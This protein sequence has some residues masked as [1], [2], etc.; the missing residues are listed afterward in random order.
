MLEDLLIEGDGLWR[1][2]GQLHERE[3]IG[4]AL[5]ANADGTVPHVRA[6]CLRRWIVVDVD[7]AIQI[8]HDDARDAAELDPVHHTV[9]EK[10]GQRDRGQV[11]HGRLLGARVLHDLRTVAGQNAIEDAG[12]VDGLRKA[13]GVGDGAREDI[14]DPLTDDSSLVCDQ[15]TERHTRLQVSRVNPL[16]HLEGQIAVGQNELVIWRTVEVGHGSHT[17][18]S[19][20]HAHAHQ[21]LLLAGLLDRDE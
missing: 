20:L 7:D 4:E 3:H 14:D 9:A 8:A 11:T 16:C 17:V 1:L 10:V 15:I 12:I 6:P 19:L 2:P 13:V 21:T 5:N 18:V